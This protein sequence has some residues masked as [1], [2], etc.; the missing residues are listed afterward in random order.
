MQRVAQWCPLRPSQ[1]YRVL[2]DMAAD[3]PDRQLCRS[4]RGDDPLEPIEH[5]VL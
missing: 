4:L 2:L 1:H 5:Q 3:E